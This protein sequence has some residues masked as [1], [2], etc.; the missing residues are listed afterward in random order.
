MQQSALLEINFK[1][2]PMSV[3]P[4]VCMYVFVSQSVTWSA[5]F[6]KFREKSDS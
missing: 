2:V 1:T 4:Q 3:C 5:L 6:L